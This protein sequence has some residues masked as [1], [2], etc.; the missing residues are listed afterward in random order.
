MPSANR[1]CAVGRIGLGT[2]QF[3]L[4]Y[5]ISNAGGKVS[6]REIS[7][8]LARAKLLGLDLIDTAIAYGD[9]EQRLGSVGVADWRVVTKLPALDTAREWTVGDIVHLVEGS[10]QRLGL[11]KLDAILL[12]RPE[13]LCSDLGPTLRAALHQC[14]KDG[15]VGRVG[16]SVYGPEDCL[17]HLDWDDLGLV[18]APLNILDRRMIESGLVQQLRARGIALHVRSVFLQGLLLMDAGARP[19][20]FGR[21]Q[22]VW[23]VWHGWLDLHGLTPLQACVR[24]A[25]S[26]PDVERLIIGVTS[27]TELSGIADAARGPL[28]D[29]PDFGPVDPILINPAR[30]SEL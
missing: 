30:W 17:K 25:L 28:P 19:G 23:S 5:G 15:L 13:Q 20:R 11:R 14:R 4:D 6:D 7:G 22:S 26:V 1:D 29:L 12:H 9:S 2:V 27:A 8:I 16:M 10:L 3:G 21:W 24:H 18:Q